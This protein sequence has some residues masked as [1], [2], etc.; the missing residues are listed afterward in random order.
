MDIVGVSIVISEP[1][2]RVSVRRCLPYTQ[3]IVIPKSPNPDHIGKNLENTNIEL[4]GQ[5]MLR[6][7]DL[8]LHFRYIGGNGFLIE[9][10]LYANVFD[11]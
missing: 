3:T 8:D 1:L 2:R 5:Y 4:D 10:C 11:D 9:S 6:L 7:R